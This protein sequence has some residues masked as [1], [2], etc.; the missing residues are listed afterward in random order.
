MAGLLPFVFSKPCFFL[1]VSEPRFGFYLSDELQAC[2]ANNDDDTVL[3][4]QYGY[5]IYFSYSSDL[6]I[7]TWGSI[8]RLYKSSISDNGIAMIREIQSNL[9]L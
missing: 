6:Y 3:F 9:L 5:V 4:R 8:I 1:S 2:L 7:S